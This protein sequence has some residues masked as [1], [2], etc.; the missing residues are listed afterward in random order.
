[1][2]F[3]QPAY[4]LA[5]MPGRTYATNRNVFAVHIYATIASIY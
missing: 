4:L 5:F 2:Y 1:M 3:I